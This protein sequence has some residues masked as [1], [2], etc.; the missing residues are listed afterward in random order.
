MSTQVGHPQSVATRDQRQHWPVETTRG[1]DTVVVVP[2]AGRAVLERF[3]RTTADAMVARGWE[4]DPETVPDADSIFVGTFRRPVGEDWLATVEFIREGGPKAGFELRLTGIRHFESFAETIGGYLGLRH[5]PTQRLLRA[6]DVAC[7][8][9][10]ALDLED[11]FDKDDTELPKFS[12][13]A[14]ADRASQELVAAVD[15]HAMPLANEHADIDAVIEFI[16]DGG[17][18]DRSPEFEYLFVPALLASTGRYA[19]A[20]AALAEFE[21]RPKSGPPDDA[22][23]TRFAAALSSWLDSPSPLT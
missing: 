11:V 21:G 16:A 17:Q 14:T 19:S 10:I 5:I 22:E 8:S 1:C 9:D 2:D 12:D 15:A 6:L 7:E 4:V 13:E 23:Y 18:T 20:R 3:I